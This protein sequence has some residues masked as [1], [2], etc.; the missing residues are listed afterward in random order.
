MRPE[1]DAVLAWATREVPAAL[2][3]DFERRDLCV[4]AS[5]VG[6]D[7]CSYFGVEVKPVVVRTMVMNQAWVQFANEHPELTDN[8]GDEE[9]LRAR[10]RLDVYAIAIDET[11]RNE[12]GK[13][14][15]HLVLYAPGDDPSVLDL[16]VKQFERPAHDIIFETGGLNIDAPPGFL[17]GEP[18][19]YVSGH[20]THA[21]IIYA[22]RPGV[23]TYTRGG[24]WKH[25]N[26]FS[27]QLIRRAR[28]EL[29]SATT[30]V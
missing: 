21:N 25:A 12:K 23:K 13:F 27:G 14:A 20:E 9:W 29:T 4:L 5:R 15:G 8:F 7:V 3:R 17:D 24:D 10:D 18:L 11:E 16:S 26:H 19:T 1:R 28:E 30:V 2:E 6:Y 22:V